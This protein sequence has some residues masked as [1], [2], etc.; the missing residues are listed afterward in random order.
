LAYHTNNFRPDFYEARGVHLLN[1]AIEWD[2]VL[3]PHLQELYERLFE[4]VDHQHLAVSVLE[5]AM[6]GGFE[7]V[8]KVIN[9]PWPLAVLDKA[10]KRPAAQALDPYHRLQLSNK[11]RRHWGGIG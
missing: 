10:L 9:M 6:T 11:L 8:E 2:L 4:E 3:L 5:T 7:H 1:W